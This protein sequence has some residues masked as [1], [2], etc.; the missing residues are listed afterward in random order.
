MSKEKLALIVESSLEKRQLD[1][2]EAFDEV[3]VEKIRDLIEQKKYMM[4]SG[5]FLTKEEIEFIESLNDEEIEELEYEIDD[6][7]LEETVATKEHLDKAL[8][9]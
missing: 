8:G 9:K 4:K 3:I 7:S 6:E 2:S 1:L 5:M